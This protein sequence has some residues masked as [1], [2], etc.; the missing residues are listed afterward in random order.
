MGNFTFFNFGPSLLKIFSL[1]ATFISV[2]G[3]RGI[4][5][6]KK[7]SFFDAKIVRCPSGCYH[8]NGNFFKKFFQRII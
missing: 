8:K 7:M 3:V 4:K 2:G 5:A 1:E 6:S